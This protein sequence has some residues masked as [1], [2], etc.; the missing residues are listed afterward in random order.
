MNQTATNDEQDWDP[1]SPEVLADPLA[2]YDRMR[3]QCPVAHSDYLHYS[4]FRHDDVLRIIKDHDTFSSRASRH[5]AVPNNMDPP[6]HT[7]YRRLIEPYFS[8]QRIAEFE[9]LC[10]RL[11]RER[12]AALPTDG[13]AD[14]MFGLAHPLALRLQCAFLGWPESLHL[15]LL[16]WIYRKNAATL[17]GNN[18]ATAA[19]ATEFDAVIRGQLAERRAAGAEAPDDATTR[20]LHETVSGRSLSE[21]EIISILRNWTVGEL[22]TIASS[23]GILASYLADHPQ[24]QQQ[25]REQPERVWRANDEILRIQAPLIA[26]RRTPS[27]PVKLRGRPVLPGERLTLMWA[28]ANRDP[29]VFE[30]PLTVR[31]D[32]DPSKNLLYGAGIHACPGAGLARLELAAMVQALLASRVVEKPVEAD[33]QT[34]VYPASGYQHRVLQW[35]SL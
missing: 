3:E 6:E 13:P 4:V 33:Q 1:R 32:R 10:R 9:P 30:A 31:L 7:A 8:G 27:C 22:G 14:V 2:A 26:N 24:L 23:I 18:Q 16:E 28:S 19:V 25:L 34:A 20:L 12:V 17:A 15:P 29:R 11:C 35:R 5:L 21:E